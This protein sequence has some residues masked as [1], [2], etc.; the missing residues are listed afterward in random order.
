MNALS[1]LTLHPK[2][3]TKLEQVF[4][5]FDK[6][7]DG[8][9]EKD[10]F[11][12]LM[13]KICQTFGEP[14]P[15]DDLIENLIRSVCTAATL[16]LLLLLLLLLVIVIVIVVEVY[17]PQFHHILNS[18]LVPSNIDSLTPLL[19]LLLLPLVVVLSIGR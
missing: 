2:A 11:T 5:F 13:C 16:A 1:K 10:E 4:K 8:D 12:K 6:N 9:L 15:S 17:P 7:G 3:L 19:L 18:N 14:P